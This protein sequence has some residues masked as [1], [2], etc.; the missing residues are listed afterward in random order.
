MSGCAPRQTAR[1]SRIS[2]GASPTGL[3][4]RRR[5]LRSARRR[6]LW[7]GCRRRAACVRVAAPSTRLCCRLS[8]QTPKSVAVLLMEVIGWREDP[9]VSSF[10]W[11]V[12][13]G[14][15]STTRSIWVEL[16]AEAW[17]KQRPRIL[18][19]PVWRR[20][21]QKPH[22]RV[23]CAATAACARL[24][25]GA[26]VQLRWLSRGACAS[27]ARRLP[28]GAGRAAQRSSWDADG[29]RSRAADGTGRAGCVCAGSCGFR[30]D[31]SCGLAG[32]HGCEWLGGE[33]RRVRCGGTGGAACP[34]AGGP[35]KGGT[36]GCA[37][38]R[39]RHRGAPWRHATAAQ[40][41]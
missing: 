17:D 28:R 32:R 15:L 21:L 23:C 36:P 2:C 3:R 12:A 22:R 20:Q 31:G 38:G 35:Q 37:G 24:S 9:A 41:A 25:R 39:S 1:S 30:C 18:R 14:V 5:V 13:D 29:R 11:P 33:P 34:R 16:D 40:H 10:F 8:V 4:P 19:F 6:H 7:Q 26:S 27:S